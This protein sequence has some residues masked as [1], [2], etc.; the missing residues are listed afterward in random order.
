MTSQRRIAGI[1]LC[2]IIVATL[3]RDWG[4]LALDAAPPIYDELELTRASL[5][6]RHGLFDSAPDALNVFFAVTQ[7]SAYPPL[8]HYVSLVSTIWAAPSLQTP[9]WSFGLFSILIILSTYAIARRI[10]D[11]KY[12]GVLAAALVS[13]APGLDAFSRI[14]MVDYPLAAMTTLA[15]ALLFAT[16]GFAHWKYSAALGAVVG[17]GMLTKQSFVIY[18]V[19]PVVVFIAFYFSGEED[20]ARIR[21]RAGNMTMAAM[22]ALAIAGAWYIPRIQAMMIDRGA[23]HQL[24][25]QVETNPPDMLEYVGLFISPTVG[26]VLALLAVAGVIFAKRDRLTWTLIFALVTP[27]VILPF[28]F[29]F[30]TPRYLLPLAP[31]AAVLG[32]LGV[33]RLTG[34]AFIGAGLA[35][36]FAGMAALIVSMIAAPSGPLNFEQQ[37]E[38][39]QFHGMPRPQY[40]DNKAESIAEAITHWGGN[41]RAVLLLDSPLTEG[42]QAALWEQDVLFPVENLFEMASLGVVPAHLSEEADLR[43]YLRESQVVVYAQ[44]A[45]TVQDAYSPEG[46]VPPYY[47]ERVFK[48]LD[49]V[50]DRFGQVRQV[51]TE[52]G[53]MVRVLAHRDSNW[54][55][56]IR[57]AH[58]P[59]TPAPAPTPPPTPEKPDDTVYEVEMK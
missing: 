47:A 57:R 50:R 22:L 51:P 35:A 42:V 15:L 30:A 45:P 25:R 17:L 9:V 28:L 37:H 27:L 24:Y 31:M 38:R 46:K 29:G 52:G 7:A 34:K 53:L 14:Y 39:F 18:M 6:L 3:A 55:D 1:L 36:V 8:M 44:G 32:A 13:V 40:V 10:S 23:I 49:A 33:R 4:V 12:T 5:L 11:D 58:T 48:A 16:R 41:R 43:R 19:A 59:S 54:L 2:L 26:P 21:V 20:R 56:D